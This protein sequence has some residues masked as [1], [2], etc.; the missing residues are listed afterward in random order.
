MALR[1]SYYKN[2]DGT[3]HVVEY[4][5]EDT[6]RLTNTESIGA[7][8][9]DVETWYQTASDDPNISYIEKLTDPS[10][11]SGFS[12]ATGGDDSD[13]APPP[14][15]G[16]DATVDQIREYVNQ[17]REA[18]FFAGFDDISA[19]AASEDDKKLDVNDKVKKMSAANARE[20]V[21][22]SRAA[23][24]VDQMSEGPSSR[25]GFG[26]LGGGVPSGTDYLPKPEKNRAPKINFGNS[27]V[28]NSNARGQMGL[29]LNEPVPLYAN[30][31]S[32][33]VFSGHNN[34]WIVLGRDRPGS[35]A[36]GYG[37]GLKAETQAGAIDICVGRMSPHVEAVNKKGEKYYINPIFDE[38]TDDEGRL[39]VDAARVYVSQKADID[40]YFKIVDTEIG[41]GNVKTRSAVGI[42]ADCVRLM[43]RDG[44]IK[45]V[46]QELGKSNS[47]FSDRNFVKQPRGIDIIAANDATHLQP[48]VLGKNLSKFLTDLLNTI[49]EIVG[50]VAQ[51]ESDVMSLSSALMFHT[52]PQTGPA[53]GVPTA[54][55]PEVSVAAYSV[56]LNGMSKQLFSVFA[57]KFDMFRLENDYL[58]VGSPPDKGIMSKFNNVN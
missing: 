27:P 6:G 43:A 48:M 16:P 21:E 40:E 46:T 34:T 17:V 30:A 39:I 31:K 1:A 5:D 4:Y 20:E 35:L 32:D 41:V 13:V 12:D 45:L 49:N 2:K 54:F 47:I 53:A 25:I 15:P 28:P 11:A 50:T 51:L 14:P 58:K 7:S 19:V 3:G 56:L 23:Q 44:G 22:S 37:N 10:I 57:Q 9:E 29:P 18:G 52:H 33:K 42:K 24:V 36:S 38:A 8:A 26:S 55:S